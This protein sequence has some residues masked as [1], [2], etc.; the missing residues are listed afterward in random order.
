MIT[1]MLPRFRITMIPVALWKIRLPEY[2]TQLNR[3]MEML[4]E[5]AGSYNVKLLVFTCQI[6]V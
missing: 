2:H 1:M 3:F 6:L 4:A 5:E